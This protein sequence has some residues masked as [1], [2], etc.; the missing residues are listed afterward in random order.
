MP[1]FFIPGVLITL[2][3]TALS[4]TEG[5]N[6]G[7]SIQPPGDVVS[8]DTASF[9]LTTETVEVDSI[10][11]KN[12]IALLG[13]FTDAF[14]GT[15]KAEFLAQV[16]CP[17]NFTFD[18]SIRRIDS[19]YLYLYYNDWFG[20]SLALMELSVYE[21]TKALDHTKPYYTNIN[22][23]NYYDKSNKIGS[24]TYST[25]EPF[26]DIET[27]GNYSSIRVTIDTAFAQRILR[28]NRIN[29]QYFANPREFSDSVLHGIAVSPSFGNGNLM[30]IEHAEFE[31]CYQYSYTDTTGVVKDTTGASYFPVTKEVR[32]INK[33]QHP[34]L[35]GYLP[36]SSGDSLNYIF[37]PAGLFTRVELPLDDIIS[38]LEGKNINSARIK[39]VVTNLDD[40]KWGMLP[41]DNLLLLKEDDIHDF[42]AGYSNADKLYSFLASYNSQDDLFSF[43][44]SSFLQKTVRNDSS[45][46]SPYNKLLMVPVSKITLNS[47][48]TST[49]F[50]VQN[51]LPKA[52][53]IRSA[54][55]PQKPMKLEI[56]YSNKQE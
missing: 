38:R 11:Y 51:I 5:Q 35:A 8:T 55:H 22:T 37:S 47:A 45:S 19:A 30:Y 12:S 31:F 34:D 29:P 10:L 25:G 39:A 4:C 43:D 40:S 15:T 49:L 46:F 52:A 1:K 7:G 17:L 24:V 32:Q 3:F 28:E 20:D 9:F 14:F 21:L 16:Y 18:E 26:T 36:L 44:L 48:S 2:L 56:V 50:L 41:P 53:K 42:F 33:Y 13:E 6:I 54:R 23:E 27:S